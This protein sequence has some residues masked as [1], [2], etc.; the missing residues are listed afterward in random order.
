MVGEW[1]SIAHGLPLL[2]KVTKVDDIFYC[3]PEFPQP[4]LMLGYLLQLNNV[5]R[6]PQSLQ[7]NVSCHF[8]TRSST[9]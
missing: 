1:Y 5:I 7:C 6:Q 9:W 4:E 3:R 8:T 2:I